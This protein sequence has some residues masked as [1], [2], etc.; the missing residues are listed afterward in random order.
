MVHDVDRQRKAVRFI[1]T[2]AGLVGSD[3]PV[4]C[5]AFDI[6]FMSSLPNMIAMAPADED[7]LVNMVTTAASITDRPVCFRFPR[8]SIVNRN[9][10]VPTGLP[11]E[12]SSNL[13]FKFFVPE[14]DCVDTRTALS[15]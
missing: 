5:G 1:I 7:E 3:G 4:Q 12:V 14:T 2:S 13:I 8:G 6:T 10:L 9:Y 15:Y 11:I